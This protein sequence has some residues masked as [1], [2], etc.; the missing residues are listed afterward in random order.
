MKI[1]A[2]LILNVAHHRWE[3]K[4]KFP[5]DCLKQPETALF[6]SF[7]LA[8]KH[9]ICILYQKIFVKNIGLKNFFYKNSANQTFNLHQQ[10]SRLL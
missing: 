5:L 7:Y 8:E 9:Q 4:K 10:K 6:L 1:T 3:A 2:Q